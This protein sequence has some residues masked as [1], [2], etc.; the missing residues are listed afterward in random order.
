MPPRS[1]D[2]TSTILWDP[3][4]QS[5]TVTCCPFSQKVVGLQAMPQEGCH[6]DTVTDMNRCFTRQVSVV[7]LG[8]PKVCSGFSARCD[9]KN[10]SKLFGHPHHHPQTPSYFRHFSPHNLNSDVVSGA[11]PGCGVLCFQV[12]RRIKKLVRGWGAGQYR[13]PSQAAVA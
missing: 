12:N 7:L 10:P 2:T 13:L 8:W 6:T 11:K 1:L 4:G 3:M 9:R 5:H